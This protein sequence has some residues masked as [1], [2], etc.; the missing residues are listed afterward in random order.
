M[1]ANERHA[2]WY[3]EATASTVY[4]TDLRT[5]RTKEVTTNLA[6]IRADRF[7]LIQGDLATPMDLLW[8]GAEPA[9]QFIDGWETD[10]TPTLTLVSAGAG[11]PLSP[12]DPYARLVALPNGVSAPVLPEG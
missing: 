10:G 7:R 12:L 1:T 2:L 8:E 6:R 3:V 11:Y 5:N 9:G 4:L